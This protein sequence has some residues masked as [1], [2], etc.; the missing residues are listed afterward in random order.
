MSQSLLGTTVP[1]NSSGGG[2][3]RMLGYDITFSVP[4]TLVGY[5]WYGLAGLLQ[6]AVTGALF[7]ASTTALLGSQAFGTIVAGW[8][9]V[10]TSLSVTTGVTYT[11]AAAI[12][13]GDLPLSNSGLLSNVTS[14]N[15]TAL[16][17]KGRFKNFG[18]GV[19]YP[20]AGPG[21][22]MF[23]VDL[24]FNPSSSSVTGIATAAVGGM[25]AHAVGTRTTFGTM[26]ANLGGVSAMASSGAAVVTTGNW[27]GIYDIALEAAALRRDEA[28]RP[29]AACPNDGEPLRQGPGGKLFCPFD[30]WQYPRDWVRPG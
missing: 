10:T 7:N 22:Y 30:G 29:P 27:W 5:R 2:G 19:E 8:N 25:T 20:N 24:L 15:I 4:G 16:A 21:D 1:P 14:G 12:D 23:F 11:V 3:H 18:T 13:G 26:T 9:E 17:G 6:S 28:S